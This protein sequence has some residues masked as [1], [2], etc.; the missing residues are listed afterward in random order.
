MAWAATSAGLLV[1]VLLILLTVQNQD[2]VTVRYVGAA[3]DFSL[4]LALLIA[5]V[6]GGILVAIAG[7]ARILQLRH[8]TCAR[9][10]PAHRPRTTDGHG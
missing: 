7:T 8:H 9:P 1:L 10:L 3:A 6:S 5:A 2:R 4:G